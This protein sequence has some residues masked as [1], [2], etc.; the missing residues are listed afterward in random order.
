[1]KSANDNIGVVLTINYQRATDSDELGMVDIESEGAEN[2]ILAGIGSH[3][4]IQKD[5]N[6]PSDEKIKEFCAELAA[7][8]RKHFGK[9]KP[10]IEKNLDFL[11]KSVKNKE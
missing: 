10:V 6:A 11:S 3:V 1:M 5:E 8:T 4:G 7:L 9:I 2:W